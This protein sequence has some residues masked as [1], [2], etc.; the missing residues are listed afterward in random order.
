MRTSETIKELAPALLEAKKQM[1]AVEKG[2]HNT[3]DGY[4]YAKLEDYMAVA[5]PCLEAH[6]LLLVTSAP[7]VTPI[8]GRQTANGKPQ[9]ACYIH[10]VLRVV[11]A[12]SKKWAEV[13]AHG[14]GQDR[15]DKA[16]YKATTGARK[17]GVAM[18]FDLKI[19]RAHV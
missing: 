19:G 13:D 11:H 6:G 9:Y 18:L 15:A 17:Y 16:V 7:T 14:E 8:E 5:R 12:E 1:T 3:H 4:D 2:G 10:L